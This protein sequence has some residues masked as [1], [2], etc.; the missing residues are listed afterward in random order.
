VRTALGAVRLRI[1]RQLLTESIMLAAGGDAGGLLI[2]IWGMHWLV[3]L[4]SDTIPRV[5]EI[6]VDPRMVGFT[7]L[8]SVAIGVFFGLAPALLASRPDCADALKESGRASA[9]VH[10]NRFR[11]ALVI[12]EV[13]LSLVSLIGAGLMIRSFAK[14][15]Q[16][17]PG[18]DHARTLTVGVTLLR[19]KYPED[20]RVASFYPSP[21]LSLYTKSSDY[22]HGLLIS[23]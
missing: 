19:S 7:L 22:P 10:R 5:R 3:S 11:S 15:N 12:S 20:E 23:Y 6:A 13:A 21:S 17:D 18:F 2:A 14:L 8:I 9:G 4:G 1:V 16:V